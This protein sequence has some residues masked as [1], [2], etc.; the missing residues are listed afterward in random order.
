MKHETGNHVVQK[1]VQEL[2]SA[3]LSFFVGVAE[4]HA[5]ELSQD[6]HGCRVIQRLLEVCQEEDI[7]KVLDPL[8]PSMEMLATNQFGN[9]VVQAIIEHRPGNDRDRIVEMVINKL[10]YFS[11]NKI[12]SNVVEKCIA[13]GSDEQRT[14]IRE[15]LCTVSASGK[16]TLFELINDQFANYVISKWSLCLSMRRWLTQGRKPSS[17]HQRS[18]AAAAGTK[19][20]YAP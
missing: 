13:F 18:R 4:E 9:Y 2:P 19:D 5:L 15:Q 8:Y 12:S 10:L 14:R 20:P 3:H 7:R 6:S 16:D 17:Q 1:F 11:K